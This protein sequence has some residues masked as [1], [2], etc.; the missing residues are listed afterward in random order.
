MAGR[1]QRGGGSGIWCTWAGE[2]LEVIYEHYE[3]ALCALPL[4]DMP[5]LAPCLLDVGVCIGFTNPVTNIIANMLFFLLDTEEASEPALLEP[6]PNG[7]KKRKRKL[8]KLN[9]KA[10]GEARVREEVLSKIIAGDGP[11]S[12]PEA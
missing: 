11:S 9:T 10:L 4:E 3:E 6:E 12:P 2:L 8:K 5:V 1:W 7:A